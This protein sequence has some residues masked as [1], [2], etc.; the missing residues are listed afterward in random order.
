MS[1]FTLTMRFSDMRV[2]VVL[3]WVSALAPPPPW[4]FHLCLILVSAPSQVFSLPS[5]VYEP[6]LCFCPRV[7]PP[8]S[9]CVFRQCYLLQFRFMIILDLFFYLCV[10]FFVFLFLCSLCIS[11]QLWS[12]LVNLRSVSFLLS[13]V[14]LCFTLFLVILPLMISSPENGRMNGYIR[15]QRAALLCDLRLIVPGFD[16]VLKSIF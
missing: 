15:K 2:F 3:M 6:S 14:L 10:L 4:R 11:V 9:P 1:L 8:I 13:Q 12:V 7:L 5:L 16:S